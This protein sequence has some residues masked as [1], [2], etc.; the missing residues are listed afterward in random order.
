MPN[1]FKTLAEEVASLESMWLQMESKWLTLAFLPRLLA[2][3][4]KQLS[5]LGAIILIIAAY[6]HLMVS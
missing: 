6:V 4:F 3:Y 1:Y 2:D 5:L